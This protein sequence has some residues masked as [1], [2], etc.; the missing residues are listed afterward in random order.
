MSFEVRLRPGRAADAG[1]LPLPAARCIYLEGRWR[2]FLG[3]PGAS[4]PRILHEGTEDHPRHRLW[5]MPETMSVAAGSHRQRLPTLLC[6]AC[7]W[8][9]GG[10]LLNRA[11]HLG[12]HDRQDRFGRL[13]A[14]PPSA[15]SQ[16]AGRALA[17]IFEISAARCR[18]LFVGPLP[19]VSVLEALRR[20]GF[21]HLSIPS[22]SGIRSS[23]FW[24]SN[25]RCKHL[26]FLVF[27]Y[28]QEADDDQG[29]MCRWATPEM[30]TEM[31]NLPALLKAMP[32]PEN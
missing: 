29:E 28:P 17:I 10:G 15:T 1:P 4:G 30:Q 16:L 24:E 12:P 25:V 22:S 9:A 5:T 27:R 20:G 31:N 6:A 8:R 21:A 2:P 13:R 32:F 18:K 19:F 26:D 14:A 11:H 3:G 7:G 23:S